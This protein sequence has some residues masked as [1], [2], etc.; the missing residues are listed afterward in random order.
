MPSLYLCPAC[1]QSVLA[2]MTLACP[3]CGRRL[4]P[5]R[6]DNTVPAPHVRI[7]EP[8]PKVRATTAGVRLGRW[9]VAASVVALVVPTVLFSIAVIK[10][11]TVRGATAA[12][13][14]TTATVSAAQDAPPA[15]VAW[16][17]SH[18]EYLRTM[19]T[20]AETRAARGDLWGALGLFQTLDAE[21]RAHTITDPE[22][23]ELIRVAA[24]ERAPI[25]QI[26]NEQAKAKYEAETAAAAAR[27]APVDLMDEARSRGAGRLAGRYADAATNG[28]AA[29]S[30]SAPQPQNSR[31][32]ATNHPGAEPPAAVA[33]SAVTANIEMPGTLED[34]KIGRSLDSAV[35]FLLGHFANGEISG[36]PYVSRGRSAATPFAEALDSLCVYALLEAREGSTDPRLDVRGPFMS[37]AL[38]VLKAYPMTGPSPGNSTS[39]VYARSMRAAALAAANRPADR[40]ALQKDVDWLVKVSLNGAYADDDPLSAYPNAV[41]S[42]SNPFVAPAFKSGS[43]SA[44]PGT[45]AW[46]GQPSGTYQPPPAQY[47]GRTTMYHGMPG[48]PLPNYD[49]P[50]PAPAPTT[51]VNVVDKCTPNRGATPRA[52]APSTT[53]TPVQMW[54]PVGPYS[55][56]VAT[57][58]NRDFVDTSPDRFVGAPLAFQ[59]DNF[60]SE[61]G[62]LGVAAGADAGCKVPDGY[63]SAVENHWNNS[64]L[65]NGQCGLSPQSPAPTAEMSYAAAASLLACH[66]R[67]DWAFH[68]NR[69]GLAPFNPALVKSLAWLDSG[70]NVVNVGGPD[71][72]AA[73][74]ALFSIE[75]TALSSGFKYFGTHD[76]YTELSD[77]VVQT[78][79]ASGGWDDLYNGSDAAVADTA[80]L[81]MFLSRGRSPVLMSKLRFEPEWNNRPMDV[82]NLA[83][84]AGT[85]LE[86]P[87]NWQVVG[88]D[89]PSSDW[90]NAPVLYISS[91]QPPKLTEADFEK[92]KNFAE[93][94][95]MIF[96]NSDSDYRAFDI[97]VEQLQKR[98]WPQ[99]DL[100][101]IPRDSA[102]YSSNYRLGPNQKAPALRGVFN[103]SRWL[104]VHCP[105]DSLSGAW[106]DATAV[107]KDRFQ[108]GVNLFIYAAGRGNYRNRLDTPYVP[109]P[110]NP[111]MTTI[112]VARLS[113][114]GNWDPE[115][116][117]WTRLGRYL[118]FTRGIAIDATPIEMTALK[119][120]DAPLAVL[121]GTAAVDFT[122]AQVTA[123][124]SYVQS[125]GTLLVDS[126]GGHDEFAKSA[127]DLLAR[128]FPESPIAGPPDTDPAPLLGGKSIVDDLANPIGRPFNTEA[129]VP[130]PPLRIFRAGTG[131]VIFTPIDL[132]SGL[133]GTHTWGIAGYDPE[134]TQRL[135]TAVVLSAGQKMR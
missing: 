18:R 66:E 21:A 14:A 39:L 37:Q 16:D 125:G 72:R 73:G 2:V 71:F 86:R 42:T 89:R 70:N 126:T 121:T 17:V 97:W 131:R 88:L 132:T 38:A 49:N 119:P 10:L 19:K 56:S 81:A 32:P 52:Y 35:N 74:P 114:D 108:L 33:S 133:L 117:A 124:R 76:W 24:M 92:L 12:T 25:T 64:V 84:F 9:I 60:N 112:N 80:Y 106:Q 111:A 3:G 69:V 85:A 118:N 61:Y 46:T 5:E 22:T 113:Y 54:V 129:Q 101:P 94:G 109:E 95:G 130:V 102:L 7:V 6:V 41:A 96:T 115:P 11:S 57:S 105:T 67:F 53:A 20:E 78:Q 91:H 50:A 4:H 98:L 82:A 68:G 62:L 79:A 93:A 23:V 45:A 75:R 127:R 63:W 135:I 99:Y 116:Y 43:L 29:A 104:L 55:V 58:Y 48:Y 8:P 83:R 59:W 15:A 120:D 26:L 44:A 90:T 28:S 30:R 122:D 123:V 77:R 87:F 34:Q 13:V 134:Y 27:A 128:A 1:G 100:K 47:Q 31:G 110:A 65:T 36:S 40:D 51:P 107:Q 103:G